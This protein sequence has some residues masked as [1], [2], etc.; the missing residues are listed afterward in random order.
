VLDQFLTAGLACVLIV[1]LAWVVLIHAG[2][3]TVNAAF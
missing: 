2:G 3:F 1:F